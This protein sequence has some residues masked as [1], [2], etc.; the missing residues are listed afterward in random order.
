MLSINA[1][2]KPLVLPQ[3]NVLTSQRN[4][5]PLRGVDGVWAGEGGREYN[6]GYS[7]KMKFKK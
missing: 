1:V 5:Y 4:P 3:L 2:G 6:C 7:V